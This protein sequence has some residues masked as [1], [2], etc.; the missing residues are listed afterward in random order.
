M[1]N[2]G[3]LGTFWWITAL[4]WFLSPIITLLVNK[5]FAYL[6]FDASRKLRELEIHTV[7]DLKQM[8][9]V[10]EEKRMVGAVKVTEC[11]SD[12]DLKTLD[13]MNKD[14]MSALYEAEYILDLVDYYQIKKDLGSSWVQDIFHDACECI[15]RC[16]FRR[17]IKVTQADLLECAQRF[18]HLLRRFTSHLNQ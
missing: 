16:K 14:L 18:Y 9:Q 8:L 6:V 15:A 13:K 12:Y 7:S 4:G 10:V 2:L 5:L 11:Q 3:T 1:A 17:R